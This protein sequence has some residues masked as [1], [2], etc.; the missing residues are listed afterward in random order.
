[1]SFADIL[2]QDRPKQ[3]LKKALQNG[4]IPN[5]YLFYG[6]ES[7]GKKLT[8]IEVAKVL[9]CK[10]YGPKDCCDQCSSCRKIE[11][12][13]HPDFFILEPEKNSPSAREAIIKIDAVRELQKKLAYLPYEGEVKVAIINNVEH[14]NPQAA[15]S[16]L[17]TLEEPPSKTLIILIACNHYQ[18]LPTIVSRCQGIRFQPLSTEF[19]RKIIAEHLINENGEAQPEELELRSHRAMGQVAR[20][21]KEDLLEVSQYREELI[22]LIGSV[23][24]ECM[25]KVFIWT[26]T[27]AKHTDSI[28]LILDEMMNLLRDMAVIKVDRKSNSIF[29][30]D[31]TRQ[32]EPLAR[33]K[34]LPVILSMFQAVQN[35]KVA[36]KSNANAQL[37][38]E[39]MLL[40]FCEA[41]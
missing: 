39:N 9:N 29:N 7:I 10:V 14:M 33:K 41:A 34:S 38:L 16:F 25:D 11:G 28:Q 27:W 5:A 19:I 40:N 31:L 13:T 18:I 24:F 21:V 23:S 4:H 2:G 22:D 15:N 36:L 32:L 26:K 12:N 8:A 30:K 6:Q 17:K 20:A 35:T 3:V 37:S 1:M